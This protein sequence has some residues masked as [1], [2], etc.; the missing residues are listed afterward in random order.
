MYYYGFVTDRIDDCNASNLIS[1][2]YNIIMVVGFKIYTPSDFILEG[3][4]YR[5]F[6]LRL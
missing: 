4:Y 5:F 3:V 2:A 1:N 6:I